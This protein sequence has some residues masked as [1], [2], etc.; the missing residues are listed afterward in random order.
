[1]SIFT[2]NDVEVH[3]KVGPY[4]EGDTLQLRC[5]VEGGDPSP[6]VV[7]LEG[8]H[9]LDEQ[10]EINSG[11]VATN[12]LVIKPIERQDLHRTF[13][14]RASNNNKSAPLQSSITLDV[15]CKLYMIQSLDSVYSFSYKNR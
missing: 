7:W 6:D 14:C 1:M 13:T 12:I 11:N 3:N 2:D 15:I 8:S 4:A 5:K 10:V 9:V